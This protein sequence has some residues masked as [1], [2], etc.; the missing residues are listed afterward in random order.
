MS[1]LPANFRS[2][3]QPGAPTVKSPSFPSAVDQ[4]PESEARMM[5][6]SFGLTSNSFICLTIAMPSG[7]VGT[8]STASGFALLAFNSID[9]KSVEPGAYC[10][11]TTTSKPLCDCACCFQPFCISAPQSVFSAK[12]AT[13]AGFGFSVSIRSK[14][15][16]V[17]RGDFGNGENRY[18]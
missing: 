7:G 5:L 11:S 1:A 3:P 6:K 15:A 18:L 16:L 14:I 2:A 12:I 13:R 8:I 4:A 9:E 17:S 10:S